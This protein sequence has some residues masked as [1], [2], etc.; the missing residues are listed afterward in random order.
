MTVLKPP[1]E[2][3][4]II[5][6]LKTKTLTPRVEEL[7]VNPNTT[8]QTLS[9]KIEELQIH[10]EREVK[11][12]TSKI[13]E[14]EVEVK[15]IKKKVEIPVIVPW[16]EIVTEKAERAS[17]ATQTKGRSKERD[18]G[19][20]E[21]IQQIASFEL[22]GIPTQQKTHCS[23]E[24][25]ALEQR[26]RRGDVMMEATLPPPPP[27]QPRG[28]RDNPSTEDERNDTS[29]EDREEPE[30]TPP[31]TPPSSGSSEDEEDREGEEDY[32]EEEVVRRF[33]A[34]NNKQDLEETITWAKALKIEEQTITIETP[35]IK[36]MGISGR[37]PGIGKMGCYRCEH[38]AR[39]TRA[40]SIHARNEHGYKATNFRWQEQVEYVIDKTLRWECKGGNNTQYK[41]L[42]NCPYHNCPYV[43]ML[44]EAL[45]SHLAQVHQDLLELAN[46]IGLLYAVITMHARNFAEIPG[47]EIFSVNANNRR[48]VSKMSMVCRE[49]QTKRVPAR[50]ESTPSD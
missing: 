21:S 38:T 27:P 31:P 24:T 10:P 46:E 44:P 40:L 19:G 6:D 50:K 8:I 20:E 12:V 45:T 2:G 3:L 18:E 26:D 48:I 16:F 23:V 17:R 4:Q 32:N 5:P 30:S 15:M 34:I 36:A 9:P 39:S 28:Q 49:R 43:G 33:A 29:E 47:A 14:L 11:T 41:R 22:V 35:L 37:W 42:A 1:V 7:R 25:Q 13:E